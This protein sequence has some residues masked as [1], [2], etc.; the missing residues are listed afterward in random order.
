MQLNL[1]KMKK[2]IVTAIL[3]VTIIG[4]SQN[5]VFYKPH[6]T[7]SNLSWYYQL[8]TSPVVIEHGAVTSE[9]TKPNWYGAFEFTACPGVFNTVDEAYSYLTTNPNFL[10]SEDYSYY[11]RNHLDQQVLHFNNYKELIAQSL[12]YKSD[13]EVVKDGNEYILSHCRKQLIFGE[14]Y[15][16]LNDQEFVLLFSSSMYLYGL[17]SSSY[18]DISIVLNQLKRGDLEGLTRSGVETTFLLKEDG[19]W[20]YAFQGKFI[21]YLTSQISNIDF[22][23][24]DGRPIIHIESSVDVLGNRV[25]TIKKPEEEELKYQLLKILT[26]TSKKTIDYITDFGPDD[27]SL[28]NHPSDIDNYKIG[29]LLTRLILEDENAYS[30]SSNCAKYL[31]EYKSKTETSNLVSLTKTILGSSCKLSMEKQYEVFNLFET[32]Y[33]VVYNINIKKNSYVTSKINTFIVANASCGYTVSNIKSYLIFDNNKPKLLIVKD[34]ICSGT[35]DLDS[36]QLEFVF[37]DTKINLIKT[38]TFIVD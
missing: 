18:T 2:Y 14:L 20:K 29:W 13:K 3:L 37:T 36:S 11:N 24:T 27:I 4:Y 25:A 16:K 8:N 38:N 6:P 26:L 28:I 23:R 12:T 9:N 21:P 17:D 31:T 30:S 32:D 10:D 15:I 22:T 1:K 7:I 5:P 35:I 34:T 19:I 33:G